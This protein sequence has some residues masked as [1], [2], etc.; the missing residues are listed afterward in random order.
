MNSTV[1]VVVLCLGVIRLQRGESFVAAMFPLYGI[2]SLIAIPLI[3]REWTRY[4]SSS[5]EVTGG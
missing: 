5:R 4:R 1:F 2:I 3:A